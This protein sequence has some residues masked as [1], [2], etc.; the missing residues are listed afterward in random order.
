MASMAKCVQSPQNL[1]EATKEHYMHTWFQ[2]GDYNLKNESASY[3]KIGIMGL[4]LAQITLGIV[5]KIDQSPIVLAHT[6]WGKEWRE[7]T[8]KAWIPTM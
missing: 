5:L 6:L 2:F 4:A 8:L 3:Q 1:G 7:S